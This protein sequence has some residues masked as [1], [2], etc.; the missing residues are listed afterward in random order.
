MEYSGIQ[1]MS[2]VSLIV[3][4][5]CI[6]CTIAA[7]P[8]MSSAASECLIPPVFDPGIGGVYFCSPAEG[9]RYLISHARRA[10]TETGLSEDIWVNFRGIFGDRVWINIGMQ[11][12]SDASLPAWDALASLVEWMRA[13]KT[14]DTD[15]L[16]AFLAPL[17]INP[18]FTESDLNLQQRLLKEL[19]A[20]IKTPTD[21][22]LHVVLYH[23]HLMPPKEIQKHLRFSLNPMLSIPSQEDL[24]HAPR[25]ATLAPK[26]ESKI[27]VPAGIWTYTWDQSQAARFVSQYYDGPPEAPFALKF[28]SAYIRFATQEYLKKGLNNPSTI[29]PERLKDYIETLRSTGAFLHFAFAK[30]WGT[31]QYDG[32]EE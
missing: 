19:T 5:W 18:T 27:A 16:E 22:P 10:H 21:T 32:V 9:E 20:S 4:L 1:K 17:E 3:G 24:F 28:G 11:E 23:V 31:V 8:A 12:A 2:F 7:Y 30:D 6:L 26:S 25:L 15:A 14:G 29:T 13:I